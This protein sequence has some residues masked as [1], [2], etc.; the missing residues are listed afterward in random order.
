MKQIIYLILFIALSC[1][2]CATSHIVISELYVNPTGNEAGKEYIE[3]YNPTSHPIDI[4]NW[5]IRLSGSTSYEGAIPAGSVIPSY[6]FFLITNNPASSWQSEWPQP[7][8]VLDYRMLGNDKMGVQVSDSSGKIVDSVGWGN[9]YFYYEYYEAQPRLAPKEG[10]CLERNPADNCGNWIDTDNNADDFTLSA[11]NPQNSL[12]A[13]KE[14][15]EKDILAPAP[16]TDLKTGFVTNSTITWSWENPSDMDF[17]ENILY[18]NEENLMNTSARSITAYDLE[19]DTEYVLKI[20]TK[21]TNEN[22]N[23]VPV[24]YVA[25]TL[26][27]RNLNLINESLDEGAKNS[28][29]EGNSSDSDLDGIIDDADFCAFD[30][31]N[32]IDEDEYCIDM[33]NCP[34]SYNEDQKD[35]DFD[36][37]G[38][39]CDICPY[40]ERRDF[41]SD[42]ICDNEDHIWGNSSSIETNYGCLEFSV[43]GVN[44]MHHASY[45]ASVVIRECGSEYPLI[46]FMYDFSNTTLDLYSTKIFKE[47]Y[48]SNSLVII[49]GADEVEKTVYLKRMLG[50]DTL[51]I[52]DAKVS[53]ISVTRDC[54]NGIKLLCNDKSGS[55][56]CKKF[57]NDTLYKI[58][59]LTH[60]ALAEY[61]YSSKDTTYSGRNLRGGLIIN[62]TDDK[63]SKEAV[64]E[65]AVLPN[66]T[67]NP[68]N[69]SAAEAK[70]EKDQKNVS[71]GLPLIT[72]SAIRNTNKSPSKAVGIALI[73][74]IVAVTLFYIFRSKGKK[75][76]LF[77]VLILFFALSYSAY[78]EPG[79][80]INNVLYNPEGPEDKEWIELYNPT[81]HAIDV[82]DWKIYTYSPLYANIILPDVTIQPYSYYLIGDNSVDARLSYPDY[83]QRLF[84]LNHGA[85]ILLT[86]NDNKIVDAV[87]WGTK[88]ILLALHYETEPLSLSPEG[89]AVERKAE[90]CTPIDTDD[91]SLDFIKKA[92]PKNRN[93]EY[94]CVGGDLDINYIRGQI[95]YNGTIAEPG[96]RYYLTLLKDI[97]TVTYSWKVDE[98]VPLFM[99]ERGLFDTGDQPSFSTGDRFILT[100][101]HCGSTYEGVLQN[102]GNEGIEL[103]C[104]GEEENSYDN[105]ILIDKEYTEDV[106]YPLGISGNLTSLK[107]TGSMKKGSDVEI[108]LGDGENTLL[109]LD[110]IALG[111]SPLEIFSLE[112]EFT[113]GVKDI[114]LNLEYAPDSAWDTDNNGICDINDSIDLTVKNS[115]FSWNVSHENLCTLWNISNTKGNFY[116]CHGS[117]DCCSLIG[118][119]TSELLWDSPFFITYGKSDVMENNIISAQ[120]WYVNYS[121][122]E[123]APYSEIIKSE[124]EKAHAVF[125]KNLTSFED[126]CVESCSFDAMA[127][128]MLW[129]KVTGGSIYL[130]SARYTVHT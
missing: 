51:C 115:L 97:G 32:D 31:L 37:V 58:T 55:Y 110:S 35:S 24:I 65:D 33:D 130:E 94:S 75:G 16:I 14:P 50:S 19:S 79:I 60:T 78:A 26:A 34:S 111:E 76:S 42:G 127:Q 18:I 106:I 104:T 85:G 117:A 48:D 53:S 17:K 129:I 10:M 86:D 28:S 96:T 124:A 38:D 66:S 7:D 68:V 99:K 61:S 116:T 120:V 91:N 100:S 123:Y 119:E 8:L 112:K 20:F 126:M 29:T 13:P 52:V 45:R 25:R 44:D 88:E 64:K 1:I 30:P 114:D 81:S 121:L 4:S 82:S 62:R 21:D 56:E 54:E 43:D 59:G 12:S 72:G 87:G 118:I 89:V 77:I 128:H 71:L 125:E 23:P 109:V 108:Y 102:G 105:I 6:G 49:L 83:A 9:V 80:V 69:L 90:G 74:L 41:D 39:V 11:P 27:N 103:D 36:G 101:E 63:T 5:K 95:L 73:V 2:V 67:E 122:D 84:L 93:S 47:K 92:Q 46:E 70:P 22:I 113:A 3:L 40:D 57:A 98:N 15:C 107:L